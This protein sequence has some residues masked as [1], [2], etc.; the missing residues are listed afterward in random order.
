[1][2]GQAAQ[3][4]DLTG[5]TDTGGRFSDASRRTGGQGVGFD[6]PGRSG[7]SDVDAAVRGI[8]EAR[9]ATVA[10]ERDKQEATKRTADAQ[11]DL[12]FLTADATGKR[13]ML[14]DEYTKAVAA[15]GANSEAAIRAK[16]ALEQYNQ[17][18]VKAAGGAKTRKTEAQ[19]AAEAEAT[20]A[21]KIV[22]IQEQAAEKLIA[23]D[24]RVAEER[25]KAYRDLA[26]TISETTADMVASQEANDLDLV[27]ASE[28]QAKDLAAREQAEAKARIAAAE[29]VSEAQQRSAEGDAETAR[30]VYDE[31]Q[32]Q[33]GEQQDLDEKYYKKQAELA[34][35]DEA[36]AALKQQYD[37]ATQ[38]IA[39]ATQTRIQ[40]AED[41]ARQKQDAVQAEK[42]A[43][44]DG[45]AAQVT[46]LGGTKQAADVALSSV[47]DLGTGL[48]SLP[49][50]VQTRVVVTYETKG[51]PPKE[52]GAA[53]ATTSAGGSGAKMAGGG[54]LTGVT[55][56]PMTVTLGDNPGGV[57]AYSISAVPISGTGR[58]TAG[59]GQL[60]LAG[61]TQG[62][63]DAAAAAARA[64]L[65]S[66][67]VPQIAVGGGASSGGGG[68][69]GGGSAAANADDQLK[70][71]EQALSV[72]DAI[73]DLE[74]KL[75]SMDSRPLDVRKVQQLADDAFMAAQALGSLFVTLSEDQA[76]AFGRF[77]DTIANAIG[78]LS[79]AADLRQTLL[80]VGPPLDMATVKAIAA[81]A[82]D[83]VRALGAYFVQFSQTQTD[84]FER[85]ADTISNAIGV[86]SDAAGLR[87]DL[88]DIGPPLDESTLSR[89]GYEAQQARRFIVQYL[90]PAS[91]ATTDAIGRYVDTAGASLDL[92]SGVAG[93]R[94][95]LADAG[96][97]LDEATIARLAHDAQAVTRVVQGTLLP[98]TQEEADAIG[99]YADAAGSAADALGSTGPFGRALP[100]LSEPD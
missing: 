62:D 32:K 20:T 93:L 7:T 77:T 74:T 70:A 41:E 24:Q 18:Q 25:A 27:G 48:T 56:G 8:Q 17:S 79:D 95:D 66:G 44:L 88:V 65:G 6:A 68:G 69:G 30:K 86:L 73:A 54:T 80:A 45:A 60:H 64:R 51:T 5:G 83:A 13:R 82:F 81:E 76:D 75:N 46:A 100:G 35:N 14:T 12:N 58:S 31:R 87:D 15:E 89:L 23:I 22:D 99:A 42:Q 84:Q 57:E 1:L 90:V 85:F 9:D 26:Q 10:A 4:R 96:P 2:A 53:P 21:A 97:P 37:E 78:V 36:Q 49:K 11:R 72:L 94:S 47:R 29:A 61:G 33:I 98:T 67:T 92:L 19:K 71:I 63:V 43:V 52:A 59:A 55:S 50:E 38:E 3:T 91:E 28:D 34:G 16:I 40:L 39:N